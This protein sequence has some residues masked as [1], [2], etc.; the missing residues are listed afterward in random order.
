M[1][2]RSEVTHRRKSFGRPIPKPPA[3]PF[4]ENAGWVHGFSNTSE[5]ACFIQTKSGCLNPN[6]PRWQY[7]GALGIEFRFSSFTEFLKCLGRRPDGK[8][9]GR[10]RS[11]GHFE[12]G[13]VCWTTRRNSAQNRIVHRKVRATT[14]GHPKHHAKGL[15]RSCYEATPEIRAR[16]A[17]CAAARY[18]STP[19]KVRINSCGHLDR[20]H[21]A[22]GLCFAC[23][24]RSPEGRTVRRRYETSRKGKETRAR[25]AA[26]P[27]CRAHQRAYAKKHYVP[28]PPRPRA[29]NICGHP[30]RPHKAKGRCQACYDAM[31]SGAVTKPDFQKPTPVVFEKDL[32]K[33][34]ENPTASAL[35]AAS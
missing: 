30:D 16:K 35:P 31:R 6:N 14:C 19:R 10:I 1:V 27:E 17:A 22:F 23:Y 4:G 26:A 21:Y 8:I 34:L 13:N 29:V 25:Y 2:K 18:V 15:C 12:P 11:D 9:L 7:Y 3:G 28:R 20:P 24:R 32:Q 33:I 5:Y